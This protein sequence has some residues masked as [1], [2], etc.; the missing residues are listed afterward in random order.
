M[1]VIRQATI[2]KENTTSFRNAMVVTVVG[3][4]FLTAL[5][6]Y[7]ARVSGSVALYAD[8][9]NSISDMIYSLLLAFGLYI[10]LKPPDETHPQG[11]SRFEPLVGLVVTMSM[12]IAG[13][14]AGRAAIERLISGG[15]AVEPGLPTIILILSALTKLGMF[16]IIRS[17]ARKVNSPAL[18]TAAIDNVMDVLT[19]S[20]ALIGILTSRINPIFDAIAGIL[21]ALWIFRAAYQAAVGHISLLTGGA[22]PE[23]LRD[24]IIEIASAQPGVLRVHRVIAEYVGPKLVVEMHINVTDAMTIKEAHAIEDDLMDKILA[25]PEVDRVYVHLEP[26][27]NSD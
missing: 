13:Y 10:S 27:D 12:A 17:I 9:V 7:G 3:N 19:S 18:K 23:E 6:A 11:H 20:V 22:P 21:V 8:A 26:N 14:T 15:I 4:V 16:L 2:N 24:Q 1:R 25:I 5:K